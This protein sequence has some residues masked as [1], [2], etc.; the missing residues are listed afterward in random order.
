MEL[1]KAPFLARAGRRATG[2]ADQSKGT[3]RKE[4][5]SRAGYRLESPTGAQLRSSPR[6]SWL[7]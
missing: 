1:S 3:L 6:V 5:P 7:T 4:K 2:L